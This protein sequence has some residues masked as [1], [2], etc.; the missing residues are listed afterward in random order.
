MILDALRVDVDELRERT[1]WELKPVGACKGDYCVPL[2][3][4]AVRDGRVDARVLSER[5][6]MPLVGDDEHGVW[7]LGPTSLGGRALATAQAP[8]LVLPDLDGNTFALTGLR[9]QKVVLVT[10]AAW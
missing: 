2:P 3:R 9:G 10:W 6:G 8:E 4:D 5:L 1:G 7:A